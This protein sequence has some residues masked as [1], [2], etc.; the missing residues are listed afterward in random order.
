MS[1]KQTPKNSRTL[2]VVQS[3]AETVTIQCSSIDFA[4]GVLTVSDEHGIV[5]V[6]ANPINAVFEPV[7]APAEEPKA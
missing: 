1:T 5:A 4:N 7:E 6:F 3:N 2:K